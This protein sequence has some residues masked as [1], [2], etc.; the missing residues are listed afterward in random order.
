MT[1]A[2]LASRALCGMHAHAVRVETHL[3]PGLPGFNVVGLVDTE[4]RESRERVRA[5]IINSGFEFPAGRITVNLSPADMP[6]ESGRFDLPI[7]LGVL[8]ASGQ[9]AAPVQDGATAGAP[10]PALAGLVLAGELSLTGALVP[11]AAPLV[12]ALSVARDAPDATLILP[13]GSAEQAAWV[14]GL[15]VLSARCLA[16]VAA[17]AAGACLLPNAVP[18]P[19]PPAAPVPCLSDVRGQAGARRALEVAA[20]GGH[21]LLMLGPPGAGKS[22]LAARLPGLLPP[23]ERNQALEAAAVATMAGM[24]DT[25]TGQPPFRAPH[26]SASVAALVGGGGRPRPGEISLAHHGVLFLDELPEFSRRSLE[27]LREPLE[28]GRVVISRALHAAQFP[29]RFQLVAAMNPCPCGWRGHPARTCACTPDQVTRY[30]GKI[31]GPLLDRI[32]LHVALPPSDPAWM[33]AP[34][35]ESSQAVRERVVRCRERQMAR[36][37]KINAGLA[38]AELDEFCVMDA[39]AQALLQQA[40]RRLTGSARAMHR[41]LRVARTIADLDGQALLAA[42]HVAQAVQYRRTG[43]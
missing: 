19:W 33:T 21:S 30:A 18:A 17:H 15:R 14:P 34:P 39:D 9:L 41:A 13:A 8:L 26:H 29:A 40:M 24:P 1:L 7:A 6:K 38:G 35:G 28:A 2:V 36:Q 20:A 5:A 42:S 31:S 12:I 3:G 10:D 25:L 27:A 43:V 37:G 32:D 16:D 4:V 23:L 22:M 11:V